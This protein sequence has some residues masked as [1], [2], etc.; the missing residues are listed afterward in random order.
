MAYISVITDEANSLTKYFKLDDAG[1]LSKTAPGHLVKGDIEAFDLNIGQLIDLIK[2]LQ[3][4]QCLCLGVL[5]TPE[6]QGI[7]C[8]K[9][10]KNGQPTRS[11]EFLNF[12]PGSSFLLLDFD[13]SGKTPEEALG[14]LAQIDPQFVDC[15]IAVIP[16]SSSYLYNGDK[17]VVGVGNFHM[18][19]EL[20]GSRDPNE[21]S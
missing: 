7:V 10:A 19:I 21:L 18:F 8:K 13:D 20:N 12:F 5:D 6:K 4:N 3:Q 16:S 17:E 11:K 14:I 15:G 9:M 1:K 2:G